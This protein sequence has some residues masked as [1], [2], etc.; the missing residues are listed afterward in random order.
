MRGY[1]AEGWQVEQEG[2]LPTEVG[3]ENPRLRRQL[4]LIADRGRHKGGEWCAVQAEHILRITE[5]DA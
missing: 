1:D 3:E 4:E 2:A 5:P